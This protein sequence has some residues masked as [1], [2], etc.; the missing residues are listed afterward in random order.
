MT[1]SSPNLLV[2]TTQYEL[3][4]LADLPPLSITTFFLK[5]SGQEPASLKTS[6]YCNFVGNRDAVDAFRVQIVPDGDVQLE[7]PR[8]RILF[9]GNGKLLKKVYDKRTA[10]E[11][12]VKLRFGQYMTAPYQSGAYLMKVREPCLKP[13]PVSIAYCR[14]YFIIV[15]V[16]SSFLI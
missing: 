12:T 3:I 13:M 2:S 14:L 15:N 4:I 9:S 5:R 7:N 6:V 16:I 10:K 11:M 8:F 1:K